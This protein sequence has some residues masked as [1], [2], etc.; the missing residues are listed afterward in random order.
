V[1]LSDRILVMSPRPGRLVD[2]VHV[3]LPR[4]R[5]PS[6]RSDLEFFNAASKVREKLLEM[7]AMSVDEAGP[8]DA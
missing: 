7:H 6:M 5:D 3:K 4:K 2:E 8:P 1:F